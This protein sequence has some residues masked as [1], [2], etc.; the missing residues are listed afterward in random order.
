MGAVSRRP[1]SYQEHFGCGGGLLV[2]TCQV[3]HRCEKAGWGG[4]EVAPVL[5]CRSEGSVKAAEGYDHG[6]ESPKLTAVRSSED[7][8]RQAK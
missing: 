8:H 3:E 7:G 6:E 2:G 4:L 1:G 5:L